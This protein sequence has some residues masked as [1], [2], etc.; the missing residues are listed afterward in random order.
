MGLLNNPMVQGILMG[1]AAGIGL[2]VI[3]A[4]LANSLR[5]YEPGPFFRQDLADYEANKAREKRDA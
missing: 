1:F 4:L 2:A 3:T 5:G